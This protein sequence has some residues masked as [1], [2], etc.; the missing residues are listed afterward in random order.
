MWQILDQGYVRKVA[1]IDTQID[2]LRVVD[3]EHRDFAYEA[4]GPDYTLNEWQELAE[5]ASDLWADSSIAMRDLA[6]GNGARYYHFLQPNQYIKG[7]KLLSDDEKR[8]AVLA[9]GGYGNVYRQMFPMLQKRFDKLRSQGVHF[10]D[11][12]YMFKDIPDTLYIDNCCHLNPKGYD[13]V[14]RKLT[15]IIIEDYYP[16]EPD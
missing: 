1:K 8:N 16:L 13:I 7:A 12:T 5:Y 4:L 10:H 3:K 11:L 6:E 9:H 14:T 2:Q 15:E